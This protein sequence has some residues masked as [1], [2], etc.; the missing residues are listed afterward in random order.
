MNDFWLQIFFR[1]QV[2]FMPR[3]LSDHCPVALNLGFAIEKIVKSFQFFKHLISAP[4]FLDTVGEAW[5]M[6]VEGDSWLVLTKKLRKV[7]QGLETLNSGKGNL[8]DLVVTARSELLNFQNGLPLT[9]TSGQLEEEIKLRGKL[10]DAL[11]DE[12]VFLKQ[13]SRVN[14]LKHGDSNNR[15]FFNYSKGRWKTNKLLSLEDNKGTTVTSHKDISKVAVDFYMNLLE[16]DKVVEDIP[17][18][19]FFPQLTPDQCSRLSTPFDDEDVFKTLNLKA[20]N[21]A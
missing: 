1:S 12:E 17:Y 4:G 7:K 11:H 20:K 8:H 3:G 5:N 6:E 18:D 9:P 21:R 13:K 16:N 2:E 19:L 10:Y 15:Y 14:W